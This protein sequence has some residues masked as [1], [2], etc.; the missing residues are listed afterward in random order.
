MIKLEEETN[1]LG[2]NVILVVR[3]KIYEEKYEILEDRL[4]VHSMEREMCLSLTAYK[5]GGRNQ[6]DALVIASL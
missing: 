5:Y 3:L 1:F 2:R 6:G 4:N